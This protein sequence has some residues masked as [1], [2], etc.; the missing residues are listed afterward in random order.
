MTRL[1]HCHPLW[2][3][4]FGVINKLSEN[5]GWSKAS[6]IPGYE[7]GLSAAFGYVSVELAHGVINAEG[8]C[9][10]PFQ[11]LKS[12][13]RPSQLTWHRPCKMGHPSWPA[14]VQTEWPITFIIPM[15]LMDW[16]DVTFPSLSDWPVE[17]VGPLLL[18]W[19]AL[20]WIWI[21]L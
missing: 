10:H 2:E 11:W 9:D 16:P 15:G 6:Q 4:G 13:L 14:W 20:Y 8:G 3:C 5:T 18:D 12:H 19:P 21:S 7:G 17:V 1:I